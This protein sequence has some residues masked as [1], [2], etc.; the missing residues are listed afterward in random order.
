MAATDPCDGANL[1]DE[2][3]GETPATETHLLP[4]GHT[5]HSLRT[6]YVPSGRPE[7]LRFTALFK[8]LEDSEAADL[9]RALR[10][11]FKIHD[12]SSGR[13]MKY[14]QNFPVCMPK[15]GFTLALDTQ[16]VPDLFVY[17]ALRGGVNPTTKEL[18]KDWLFDNA[19]AIADE[20]FPNWKASGRM[21]KA[22]KC[23]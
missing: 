15:D 21:T 6:K 8:S 13:G 2:S 23:S 16:I 20:F 4:D 9:L 5:F 17:H 3:I 11:I 10:T 19:Q 1:D 18:Q 14:L 12:D 7:N 22:A